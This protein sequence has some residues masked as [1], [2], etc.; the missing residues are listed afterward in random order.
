MKIGI[1]EEIYLCQ[2]LQD[3]KLL[4]FYFLLYDIGLSAILYIIFISK[5]L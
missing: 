4:Y 3:V 1:Y 5:V 2:I